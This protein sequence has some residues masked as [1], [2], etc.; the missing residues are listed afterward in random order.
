MKL[1]VL[2]KK[3]YKRELKCITIL[4]GIF[5]LPNS[6][7]KNIISKQTPVIKNKNSRRSFR[8]SS[9]RFVTSKI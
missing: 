5:E 3:S 1:H 2:S 9:F 8:L 4:I 7:A 6:A